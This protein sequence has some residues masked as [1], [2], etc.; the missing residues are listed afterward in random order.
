MLIRL[1]HPE[2]TS[3]VKRHS[4]LVSGSAYY[5]QILKQVQNDESKA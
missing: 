1:F 2:T 5:L 4:E 3:F